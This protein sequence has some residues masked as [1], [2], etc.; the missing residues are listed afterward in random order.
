MRTAMLGLDP[1]DQIDENGKQS[2]Q[3]LVRVRHQRLLLDGR[4][5]RVTVLVRRH[6]RLRRGWQ[7]NGY[8][9]QHY[10]ISSVRTHDVVERR[11]WQD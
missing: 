3:L 6:D 11:A 5:H 9:T 10:H 7:C 1:D 2:A 4:H 8:S